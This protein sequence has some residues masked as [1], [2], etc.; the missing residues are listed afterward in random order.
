MKKESLKNEIASTI[1]LVYGDGSESVAEVKV[2]SLADLQMIARGWLMSSMSAVAVTAYDEESFV[3][4]A[5][6]K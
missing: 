3:M 5:Y 2:V 4:A 1:V 6:Q